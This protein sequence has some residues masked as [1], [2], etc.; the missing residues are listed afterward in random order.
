[1][2]NYA[3]RVDRTLG[4]F[5][6]VRTM[7]STPEGVPLEILIPTHGERLGAFLLDMLFL[8]LAVILLYLM[9][10][11]LFFSGSSGLVGG[12]VLLFLIFVVRNLYFLHFELAWQGRTPGKKICGLRVVNREGGELTPGAVVARNLTREVE[13]F[14]PLSLFFGVSETSL[15]ADLALLGWALCISLVPLF[16]RDH[17]RVGDLLGGTRVI[18]MPRRALSG[19]LAGQES[20]NSSREFVFT[21][22]QLGIYGAY[23]LQVLEEVLR[24]QQGPATDALLVRISEKIRHKIG[25]KESLPPGSD[26]RFLTAFYA[27]ERAELER[28]QLMGHLREDKFARE[29]G[30]E[31]GFVFTGEQLAVYGEREL[32]ALTEAL[33]RPQGPAA[34]ELLAAIGAK[35]RRKIGWK[36]E[37]SPGSER[38]FLMAF[39]A[40]MQRELEHKRNRK[41]RI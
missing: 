7:L 21:H 15:W 25:W 26:R 40:A 8:T 13:I 3:E 30:G 29:N 23:E 6:H 22:E 9:L 31:R 14:M 35:I 34:D 37:L 12:T 5:R 39:Q 41:G 32:K 27:A 17:L 11:F 1:M 33:K 4:D 18:A 38:R 19:D 24:G 20:G 10:I 28:A 16:N 36:G 2:A